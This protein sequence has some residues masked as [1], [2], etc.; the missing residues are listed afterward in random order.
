MRLTEEPETVVRP[1]MH[2]VFVERTGPFL[3][4]APEAWQ[5]AHRLTPEIAKHNTITGYLSQYQLEPP[6]YRAGVS[7]AEAP[8]ALPEGMRHERAEGGKYAR[9]VLMGPYSQLPEASCR[10]FGIVAERKIPVRAGF[11][12][13]NYVN[14][15]RVTPED[16]VMTEILIPTE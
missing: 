5:E 16:Q 9:F 15:P 11:K 8:K 14:D 12:I 7:V 2:Y 10:V 13:E 1:D 4:S 6:V 3:T